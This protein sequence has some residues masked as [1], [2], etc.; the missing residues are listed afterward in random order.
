MTNEEEAKYA[1]A[2]DAARREA[3]IA[4]YDGLDVTAARLTDIADDAAAMLRELREAKAWT[5]RDIAAITRAI[6][7]GGTGMPIDAMHD[8]VRGRD[9]KWLN[10][11]NK[12]NASWTRT[13]VALKRY[14]YHDEDCTIDADEDDGSKV[15]SCGLDAALVACK[16]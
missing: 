11:W 5:P 2:I 3:D 15:C 7:M 13:Y 4:K 14:G 6:G 1:A 10:A 12:L 8:I 16:E 9:Q